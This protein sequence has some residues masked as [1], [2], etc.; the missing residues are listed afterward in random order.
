MAD[1]GKNSLWSD[2]KKKAGNVET[3]LMGPA[4]SYA[5]HL[6][7]PSGE[8]GLGV[9]SDG[10]FSQLGTN[11][12]AVG[13]YVSTMVGGG[14][15]LGN[16]YYVNTGGTC[17]APD[18]SIQPR[19]NY[20]N[21][22]ST[23][24]VGGV[25]SDIGGLNPLYLVNSMTASA[26]PACKCYQCPVTS[27]EQYRFLSPDLSPDFT[28]RICKVVDSSKCMPKSKEGFANDLL[29]PLVVAGVALTAVLLLRK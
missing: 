12:G 24:L 17:T 13:T 9:G 21:N 6:P 20:I 1:L 3:D 8:G 26:S 28:G 29:I 7:P 11:L 19:Y 16:Q 23:G 15:P 18:G 4:Y 10:T 14:T 2:V 5:D 22:M 25:I 27:G